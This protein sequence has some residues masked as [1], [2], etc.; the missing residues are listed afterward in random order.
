MIETLR[1]RNVALVEDAVLE[2]GPGLNVLTGETGAGK[3]IV[4][5]AL[6]LLA[7]ARGSAETVRSGADSAQVEAIFD[8]RRQAEL[9]RAL[10]ARGTELE[11]HELVVSRALSAAG[12]SRA[13]LAGQLVPVAALAEILGDHVEISSQHDSQRL[14]RPEVHGELLDRIGGLVELRREVEQGIAELRRIDAECERL[15][16][17]TA[18]REQRRDFLG[19]QLAELE[20]VEL[21]PEAFAALRSERTRLF[22]AER[23]REQG[24]AALALLVGDA[25]EGELRG[26]ADLAGEAARR[27]EGLAKLDPA[28]EPLAHRLHAAEAELRE[29]AL[30]V[31]GFCASVDADPERLAGLEST[32]HEIE[33]RLRK[34]GPELSDLLRFRE[35]LRAQLASLESAGDREAQLRASREPLVARVDAAARKLSKGRSRA[36]SGLAKQVEAT[37]RELA[38]P[39]ASFGVALTPLA[40]PPELPCGSQGREAPEFCF[41]ANAGEAPR[42]LRRVASG[43]ELSR[44]FLALKNASRGAEGGMLLVFDEVDAGV[45]GRAALRVGRCLAELAALHQ[46]ICI[47]HLPQVAALADVHFRVE[48]HESAGRTRAAVLRLEGEERVE[49]IARMAGGEVVGEATRRHARELLASGRNPP[50]DSRRQ[51]RRRPSAS[52]S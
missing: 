42:A 49:E 9:E 34:Y 21:T 39:D 24:A 26:A 31:E 17:E 35:D 29:A 22:H 16:R 48:K 50:A 8:T 20:S 40:P 6:A 32:L 36:A 23:F 2:L 28:Q 37:L 15:A 43:G 14:R 38:M 47:T 27:I 3:S 33:K 52:A 30:E 10:A 11:G 13:W 25:G 41:S 19:F 18:E 4:L 46:V 1:I 12:R 51:T 45:G 5:S 44:V 7:G